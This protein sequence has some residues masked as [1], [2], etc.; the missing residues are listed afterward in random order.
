MISALSRFVFL[1]KSRFTKNN[2]C[3]VRNLFQLGVVVVVV[4][5]DAVDDDAVVAAA[6]VD[7]DESD[8]FHDG[9][10]GFSSALDVDVVDVGDVADVEELP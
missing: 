7:E 6:A 9:T 3:D 5:D 8:D 4:V 2:R 10:F 1:F